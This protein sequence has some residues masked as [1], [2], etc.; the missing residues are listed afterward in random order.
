MVILPV[1][2][3]LLGT[4]AL[5]RLVCAADFSAEQNVAN[6]KWCS[7]FI[8]FACGFYLGIFEDGGGDRALIMQHAANVT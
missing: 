1:P 6:L 7:V 8:V 2:G 5:I 3:A 4:V